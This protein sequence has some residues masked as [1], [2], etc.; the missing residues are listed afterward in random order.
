MQVQ[1]SDQASKNTKKTFVY[2]SGDDEGNY[3]DTYRIRA[4]N[5]EE[6]DAMYK[7]YF[8]GDGEK[9]MSRRCLD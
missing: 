5:M 1:P 6:A 2:T 8:S 3:V 9:V 7:K 4:E